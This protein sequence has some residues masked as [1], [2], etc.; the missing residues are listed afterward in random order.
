MSPQRLPKQKQQLD[1][2]RYG[3]FLW[4]V[5]ATSTDG[6]LFLVVFT[7]G[8]LT[9]PQTILYRPACLLH[10]ALRSTTCHRFS[11]VLS[12][13]LLEKQ[14]EI[15]LSSIS[16]LLR[17]HCDALSL[18]FRPSTILLV[19]PFPARSLAHQKQSR[20]RREALTVSM[21]CILSFCQCQTQK[22]Q[23]ARRCRRLY[24]LV[25]CPHP[26]V[27]FDDSAQAT[28]VTAVLNPPCKVHIY[29]PTSTL[30]CNRPLIEDILLKS[31]SR[32]TVLS[33]LY[34]DMEER[35]MMSKDPCCGLDSFA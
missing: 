24:L 15:G 25:R 9:R 3:L 11:S 2:G 12:A 16:C 30:T 20:T 10:R 21:G 33:G 19:L 4:A 34:S 28:T 27:G 5:P 23:D 32:D 29:L 8:E 26:P 7:S 14:L 22:T 17:V 35:R 6:S 13:H 1:G 18:S 31:K